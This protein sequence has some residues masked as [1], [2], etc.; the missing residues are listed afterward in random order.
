MADVRIVLHQAEIDGLA[1]DPQ[2]RD[3]LLQAAQPVVAA[4]KAG[5]PKR[6]GEGAASIRAEEVLDGPEWTVR[7]S[8][9]RDRF[10]MYFHERG[11]RH[12]PA[13]PFLVPALEGLAR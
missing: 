6:T 3:V 12:L 10:Y 11:T 4:A 9:D 1:N 13:R 2:W 5:A 7:V 8:W